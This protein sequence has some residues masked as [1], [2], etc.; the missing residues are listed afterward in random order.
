MG[1]RTLSAHTFSVISSATTA[2][3]ATAPTA[4]AAYFNTFLIFIL[5]FLQVNPN[6][7]LLSILVGDDVSIFV[8]NVELLGVK[9][10]G[11]LVTDIM[12]EFCVD[13]NRHE[14]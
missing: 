14:L 5:V 9:S 6:I 2:E 3:P 13:L 1:T 4:S 12:R 11:Q 8:E 10:D 7:G